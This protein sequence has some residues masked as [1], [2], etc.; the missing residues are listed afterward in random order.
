MEQCLHQLLGL[1]G[2]F[3][4][5]NVCDTNCLCKIDG[6]DKAC[7]T[8]EAVETYC[9]VKSICILNFIKWCNVST[10]TLFLS[11]ISLFHLLVSVIHLCL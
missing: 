5:W 1:H 8:P 2:H 7:A 4:A 3:Q 6:A 9:Q 11:I 10:C